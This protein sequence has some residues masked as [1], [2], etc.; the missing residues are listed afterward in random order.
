MYSLT[1]LWVQIIREHMPKGSLPGLQEYM[2]A[3]MQRAKSKA[4][5]RGSFGA[6]SLPRVPYGS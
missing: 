3:A 4:T 5:E 2:E 6:L 1:I